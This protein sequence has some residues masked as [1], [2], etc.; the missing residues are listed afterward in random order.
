MTV[1]CETCVRPEHCTGRW[2]DDDKHL[3]GQVRGC[4]AEKVSTVHIQHVNAGV[5]RL[6]ERTEAAD[7]EAYKRMRKDGLQ[8]RAIKHSRGMEHAND[9][10]VIEGKPDPALFERYEITPP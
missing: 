8:P 2:P 7:M 3:P 6:A 10:H 5:I 4:Y 9:K 1:P